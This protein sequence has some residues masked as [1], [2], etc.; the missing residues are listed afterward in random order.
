[1]TYIGDSVPAVVVGVGDAL[2]KSHVT[3]S[4]P[5]SLQRPGRQTMNKRKAG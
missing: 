4:S 5:Q 3:F 2:V 1:M